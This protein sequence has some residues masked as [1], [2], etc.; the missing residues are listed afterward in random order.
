MSAYPCLAIICYLI[1]KG[2][3]NFKAANNS[4]KT[5]IDLLT[6][7]STTQTK[8]AEFLENFSTSF[9]CS[10]NTSISDVISTGTKESVPDAASDEHHQLEIANDSCRVCH[11]QPASLMC[12]VL[13]QIG[14]I[15]GSI[16]IC[17]S[18]ITKAN[19]SNP[20][21]AMDISEPLAALVNQGASTSKY[22]ETN[23]NEEEAALPMNQSEQ[24]S[25]EDSSTSGVSSARSSPRSASSS[26]SSFQA[27]T[28][29]YILLLDHFYPQ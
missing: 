25:S 8:M 13:D 19:S 3:T 22:A 21:T 4:G 20:E 11:N 5:A 16:P 28:V 12:D 6:N 1:K 27:S 18:C 10:S 23:N 7:D 29:R 9:P 14:Q 24:E 15:T 26:A 17:S 2:C